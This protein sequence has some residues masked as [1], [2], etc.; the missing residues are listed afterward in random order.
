MP[1]NEVF[2]FCFLFS[3]DI[4]INLSFFTNSLGP[5]SEDE[6][7]DLKQADDSKNDDESHWL[8]VGDTVRVQTG[9]IGVVCHLTLLS[10]FKYF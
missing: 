4:D 9:K 5:L 2:I 6:D 10:K 7:D 3:N 8:K 1:C